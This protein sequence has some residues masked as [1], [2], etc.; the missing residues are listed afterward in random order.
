[1]PGG[2]VAGVS[3]RLALA[4]LALSSVALADPAPPALLEWGEAPPGT[5]VIIELRDGNVVRG[6]VARGSPTRARPR[7]G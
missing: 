7:S 4:L 5:R 2:G 6:A 3:V 1:M